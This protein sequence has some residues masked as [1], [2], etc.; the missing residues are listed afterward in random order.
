MSFS[1]L[2]T[3][4]DLRVTDFTSDKLL[5]DQWK[6]EI[7]IC[8]ESLERDDFKQVSLFNSW[9]DLQT[10]IK[11][12]HSSVPIHQEFAI[13]EPGLTKLRTFTDYHLRRLVPT[14]ETSLFWG[15]V[16]LLIKVCNVASH[17]I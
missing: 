3:N 4:H 10:Q 5:C 15:L 1:S 6:G 8:C 12:K 7:G 17:K 11:S 16:R 13:L 9:D 2:L 14:L